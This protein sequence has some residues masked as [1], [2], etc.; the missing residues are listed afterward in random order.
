[1]REMEKER[2][3]GLRKKGIWFGLFSF[4]T[5]SSTTRLYHGREREGTR[6]DRGTKEEKGCRRIEG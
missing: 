2:E 4:L 5:S 3:R 6:V 1:M